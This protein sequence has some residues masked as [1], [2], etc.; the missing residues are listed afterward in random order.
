M[1]NLIF[2]FSQ[3][4]D[5]L[6]AS[7]I[8]IDYKLKFDE[9]NSNEEHV[10]FYDIESL[11]MFSGLFKTKGFRKTLKVFKKIRQNNKR[12]ISIKDLCNL[13]KQLYIDSNSYVKI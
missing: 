8:L 13:H 11:N 5:T 2:K 3:N 4:A 6:M 9:D 10:I 1:S 7:N 12:H